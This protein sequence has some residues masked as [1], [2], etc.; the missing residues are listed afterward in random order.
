MADSVA[1]LATA[2]GFIRESHAIQRL[3]SLLPIHTSRTVAHACPSVTMTSEVTVKTAS[4]E[5]GLHA[6]PALEGTPSVRVTGLA[7][8]GRGHAVSWVACGSSPGSGDRA[9]KMSGLF[10]RVNLGCFNLENHLISSLNDY[11]KRKETPQNG[12][13]ESSS[14]QD[15]CSFFLDRAELPGHTC[16]QQPQVTSQVDVM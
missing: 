3:P 15:S 8:L 5:G 6:H 16:A 13:M 2:W 14:L 1:D 10:V 12:K 4:S 9:Q 11:C 7:R